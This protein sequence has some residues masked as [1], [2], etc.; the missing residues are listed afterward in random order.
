MI[1][2][3]LSF[4]GPNL[5]KTFSDNE[6]VTIL[7]GRMDNKQAMSVR[8]NKCNI[9]IDI[10]YN[11]SRPKRLKIRNLVN[12]ILNLSRL[13]KILFEATRLVTGRAYMRP[14]YF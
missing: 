9:S 10:S 4:F 5:I 7:F 13:K 14:K 3:F 12:W 6:D 11:R 2:L 1:D 8:K